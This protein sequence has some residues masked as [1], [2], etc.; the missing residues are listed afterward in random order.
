MKTVEE[1]K[2][3]KNYGYSFFEQFTTTE[4]IAILID[5]INEVIRGYDNFVQ[6]PHIKGNFNKNEDYKKFDLLNYNGETYICKRNCYAPTNILDTYYFEKLSYDMDILKEAI[7]HYDSIEEWNKY[8]TETSGKI[9]EKY[10]I[11]LNEISG[12]LEETVKVVNV[13]KYGAKGDGVTDDTESIKYA[14]SLLNEGDTLY[15]PKTSSFYKVIANNNSNSIFTLNKP[16]IKVSSVSQNG[17]L[18]PTI[19]VLGNVVN[20]KSTV[21]EILNDGIEFENI[22]VWGGEPENK[23]VGDCFRTGVDFQ[24]K[25]KFKNVFGGYCLNNGYNLTTYFTTF[26]EC[27]ARFINNE[28]KTGKGFNIHGRLTDGLEGT[29]IN[30]IGCF[31]DYCDIGYNLSYLT[32]SHLSGCGC[33][34]SNEVAYNLYRCYE[35]SG[36]AIGAEAINKKALLF[37]TCLDVEF[38]GIR[39]IP[40]PSK[41]NSYAITLKSSTNCSVKKIRLKTSVFAEIVYGSMNYVEVPNII[42]NAIDN[43]FSSQ[44]YDSYQ[45]KFVPVISNNVTEIISSSKFYELIQDTDSAGVSSIKQLLKHIYLDKDYTLVVS[46]PSSYTSQTQSIIKRIKGVRGS[47]SL[48]IKGENDNKNLNLLDV[49]TNGNFK[50]EDNQS[51]IVFENITFYSYYQGNTM[52]TIKNSTVKFK[53]CTIRPIGNDV[54]YRALN[55]FKLENSKVIIESDTQLLGSSDNIFAIKDNDSSIAIKQPS[56]TF[57][58]LYEYQNNKTL[59]L[60]DFKKIISETCINVKI[61][62]PST[63]YVSDDIILINKNLYICTVGGVTSSTNITEE[64]IINDGNATFKFLTNSPFLLLEVGSTYT[65]NDYV[66]IENEGLFKVT[67]GGTIDSINDVSSANINTT[68]TI[69]PSGV[70]GRKVAQLGLLTV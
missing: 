24:S 54:S 28:N 59:S 27:E 5:K 62:K 42:T 17:I 22:S 50:I 65:V 18:L 38:N 66:L 45:H 37:D 3:L 34:H 1:L 23:R 49:G 30:F 4:I 21:F 57:P 36:S 20:E 52:F 46:L 19:K 40:S 33:D 67:V 9:E 7:S 2:N 39:I 48:I 58:K 63:N 11:R 69:S 13:K 51:E 8:F 29:T 35:V 26:T 10:T 15:F 31:T 6:V 53:N 14:I 16:Q 56:A 55:I 43:T 70:I 41:D 47:K 68:I 12:E 64:K 61:R 25:L 32:Y 44:G 60:S